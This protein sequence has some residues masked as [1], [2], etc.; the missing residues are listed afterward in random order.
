MKED[1]R[2]QNEAPYAYIASF[3]HHDRE[4][5]S[6]MEEN[7][8]KIPVFAAPGSEALALLWIVLIGGRWLVMPLFQAAGLIAPQQLRA[9][10]SI[11]LEIYLILLAFT[12]LKWSL[13]TVRRL[14]SAKSCKED[15]RE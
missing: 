4:A 14:E 5:R 13:N 15:N 6:L 7:D 12:I 9:L 10:D 2:R 3:P 1:H 8:A 11:L